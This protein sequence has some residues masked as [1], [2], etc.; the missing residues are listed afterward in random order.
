MK[1]FIN[2]IDDFVPDSAAGLVM[3]HADLLALNEEPLFIHRRVLKQNRVAL[4]SGGGSGHE[5][6]H[7]G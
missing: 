7:S 4:V 3:A 2:S 1:K 6:L 5:P